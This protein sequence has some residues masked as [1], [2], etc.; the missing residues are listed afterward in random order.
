MK[1]FFL[2]DIHG[3]YKYAK[4]GVDAFLKE[5]ADYL[6]VL[7]DI[8]YHGPRNPLPEEYNPKEVINLLNDIKEKIISV[9]GNCD[10][11]VDSMVL[12]FPMMADYSFILHNNRRI[13]ITHGHLY[14]EDNLPSLSPKDILI[15][16][17]THIP[18][19][20][21]VENIFVFNPGSVALPKENHPNTYGI[22]EEDKF[23]IKT[24]DGKIYMEFDI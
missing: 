9:R 11:E 4:Q 15:H 5:G 7:G 20:K 1:L 17:H 23:F 19:T 6:I 12:D 13:F 10:S 2:S 16:G 22:I 21:Q 14:N 8:L 24:L 18:M 3:S